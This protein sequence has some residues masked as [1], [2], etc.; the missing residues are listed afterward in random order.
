LAVSTF[1]SLIVIPT[2]YLG[3][4]S[5]IVSMQKKKDKPEE[6]GG[7]GPDL[8]PDV[9]PGPEPPVIPSPEMP[10]ILSPVKR[11]EES[12]EEELVE[13]EKRQPKIQYEDDDIVL[14]QAPEKKEIKED[15]ITPPIILPYEP[16]PPVILSPEGEES[17]EV[18]PDKPKSI[19]PFSERQ[20]ELIDY[21]KTNK[22]ITRKEYSYKF[23]ISVPTAARDLRNLLKSGIIIAKGPAAVGRHYV[24]NDKY[25]A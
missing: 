23:N 13:P 7:Q 1:L 4:D 3:L 11:D 9:V 21:L 15:E 2:I 20:K 19:E 17:R 8:L 10:V 24:L 16:E 5:I 14:E 6:S 12:G 18:T 22:Q 25:S